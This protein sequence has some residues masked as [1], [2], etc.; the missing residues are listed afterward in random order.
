ARGS[1]AVGGAPIE[2]CERRLVAAIVV[3]GIPRSPPMVVTPIIVAPV[4]SGTPVGIPAAIRV[5]PIAVPIA[6]IA[7]VTMFV[8]AKGHLLDRQGLGLVGTEHA[9]GRSSL[10]GGRPQYQ[11]PCR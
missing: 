6:P 2:A 5:T 11:H 10:C 8:P 9:G 3:R 4:P 1:D 7:P